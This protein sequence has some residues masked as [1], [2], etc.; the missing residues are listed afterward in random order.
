[1]RTRMGMVVAAGPGTVVEVGSPR[2][3]QPRVAG[4][5]ADRVAQLLVGRP[6]EADDRDL[7][8]LPSRGR[9]TGRTDQRLRCRIAAAGTA[10]LGQQPRRTHR[11]G[12]GQAGE[13][14]PV[15]VRAQLLTDLLA[16]WR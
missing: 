1:M 7:S 13:D 5:L 6:A 16:Q 9:D 14:V 4:E 11:A 3:G 8:R 12:A 10:D 2:V 15:C